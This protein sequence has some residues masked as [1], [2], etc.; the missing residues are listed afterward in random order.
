MMIKKKRFFLCLALICVLAFVQFALDALCQCWVG[1]N[2]KELLGGIVSLRH[3]RNT[4]AA[5]GFLSAAPL[6]AN[7]LGGALLIAL[8][9]YLLFGEMHPSAQLSL[10][11]VLAGG[12][13]NLY[14]RLFRGGVSDWI[15]L[16]FVRFPLFNFADICICLGA[17]LFLV[18]TLF[19]KDAKH[20]AV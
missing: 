3:S 11:A 12:A 4:G 16:N 6:L 7:L 8:T 14:M 17:M 20:D 13:C 9:A 5:F 18:F 19:T 15:E 2:E 1:E 10:C